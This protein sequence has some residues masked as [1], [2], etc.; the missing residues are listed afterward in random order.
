M[1]TAKLSPT[2][3]LRTETEHKRERGEATGVLKSNVTQMTADGP[4]RRKQRS[5]GFRPG[6]YP[7]VTVIKKKGRRK[8]QFS[9]YTLS[10]RGGDSKID[11]W[12][13]K[14]FGFR[15]KMLVHFILQLLHGKYI[16]S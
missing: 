1:G 7:I 13:V 5:Q 10:Q 8:A 4:G 16:H 12:S 11:Y 3:L 2:R 14:K 9:T 6:S 15:R